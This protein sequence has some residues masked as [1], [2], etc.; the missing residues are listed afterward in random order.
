MWL[1][2][3]L[4]RCEA[5]SIG[6]LPRYGRAACHRLK[7]WHLPRSSRA[8]FPFWRILYASSFGALVWSNSDQRESGFLVDFFAQMFGRFCEDDFQRGS[9]VPFDQ[10][11]ATRRPI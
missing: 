1:G 9:N 2:A 7:L 6:I 8:D 4:A 3:G 10:V 5:G 11:P